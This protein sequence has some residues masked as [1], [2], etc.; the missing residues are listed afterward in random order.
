ML[1]CVNVFLL[2]VFMIKYGACSCSYDLI[3]FFDACVFDQ[4][5]RMS[6]CLRFVNNMP[7]FY[8]DME[9][10]FFSCILFKSGACICLCNCKEYAYVLY[11]YGACI[12]FPCSVQIWSVCLCLQFVKNIPAFC[13]D[14][15]LYV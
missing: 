7:A 4:L 9:H 11:I 10:A 15:R 5:W 14:K 8:T 3:T 13:I 12:C 6:S 1:Y 2:I